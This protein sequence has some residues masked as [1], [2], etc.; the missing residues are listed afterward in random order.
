V[1]GVAGQL[2]GESDV[3][4][5]CTDPRPEPVAELVGG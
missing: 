4:G 1:V 3:V 2:L 5:D